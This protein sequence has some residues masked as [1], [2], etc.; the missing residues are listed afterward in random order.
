MELYLY[1]KSKEKKFSTLVQKGDLNKKLQL[2]Y[3]HQSFFYFDFISKNT[4][5][6]NLPHTRRWKKIHIFIISLYAKYQILVKQYKS[7]NE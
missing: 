6:I 4:K 1:I 5:T 7:I 2:F 3:Y